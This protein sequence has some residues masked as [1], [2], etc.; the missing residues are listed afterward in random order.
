MSPFSF[1]CSTG[2]T[3]T[4]TL[5]LTGAYPTLNPSCVPPTICA[6][7]LT[8][9]YGTNPSYA[10]TFTGGFNFALGGPY[11]FN[12][13]SDGT[14][15]FYIAPAVPPVTITSGSVLTTGTSGLNGAVSLSGTYEIQNPSGVTCTSPVTFTGTACP[16]CSPGVNIMSPYSFTCTDGSSASGTM[17]IVGPYPT[18]GAAS[19]VPT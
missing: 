13:Y 1:T 18:F 10:T 12:L 5:T 15:T 19:C 14:V 3:I 4:G 7:C 9:Q 16:T 17:T 6:C 11:N 2:L 8:V